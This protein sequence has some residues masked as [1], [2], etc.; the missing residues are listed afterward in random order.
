MSYKNKK[1]LI[2]KVKRMIRNLIHKANSNGGD[3]HAT[4]LT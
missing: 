4:S 1:E 2:R 3:Y